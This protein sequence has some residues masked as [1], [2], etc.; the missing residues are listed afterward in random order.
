VINVPRDACGAHEFHRAREM[1][2]L[3]YLLAEEQMSLLD[4]Q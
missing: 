3:G 1:I 4:Q 2:E